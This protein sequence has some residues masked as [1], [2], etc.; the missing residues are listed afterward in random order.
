MFLLKQQV[1][2]DKKK[3]TGVEEAQFIYFFIH[4]NATLICDKR[5]CSAV[6]GAI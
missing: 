3:Y 5:F 4:S 2:V 1:V 6:G